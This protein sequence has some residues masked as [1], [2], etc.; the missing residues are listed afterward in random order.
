MAD[1]QNFLAQYLN[2]LPPLLALATLASIVGW[3]MWLKNNSDVIS[4]KALSSVSSGYRSLSD[5]QQSR[6]TQQEAHITRLEKLV[7]ELQTQLSSALAEINRLRTAMEELRN[8]IASRDY[9]EL[10]KLSDESG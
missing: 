8:T 3:K 7:T 5:A 6:I 9:R 4:D 2:A 1:Y 10:K